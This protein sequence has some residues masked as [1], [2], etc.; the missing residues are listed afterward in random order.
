MEVGGRKGNMG[1]E[2]SDSREIEGKGVG[3]RMRMEWDKEVGE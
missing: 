3:R 1:R 2:E